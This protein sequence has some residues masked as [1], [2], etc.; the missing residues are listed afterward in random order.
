M[1]KPE[2][3]GKMAV[4]FASDESTVITGQMVEVS[5]GYK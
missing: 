3:I 5:G 2:D 1:A 4:F